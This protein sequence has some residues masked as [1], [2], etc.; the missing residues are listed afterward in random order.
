M[1][2]VRIIN[3]QGKITIPFHSKPKDLKQKTIASIMKQAGLK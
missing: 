1:R 3:K 2:I